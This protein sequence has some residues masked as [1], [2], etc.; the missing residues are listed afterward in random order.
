MSAN[1]R[2]ARSE[3]TEPVVLQ[4]ELAANRAELNLAVPENLSYFRGHFP[5]FATLPGVVQIEWVMGYAQR[6]LNRPDAAAGTLRIKFRRPIRPG[7]RLLLTLT[8]H[9]V[10]NQ[11]EFSYANADGIFSAGRIGLEHA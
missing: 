10:R 1:P 8:Y 6:Y 9:S 11:I 5:N 7:D 2:A 4:V 3:G